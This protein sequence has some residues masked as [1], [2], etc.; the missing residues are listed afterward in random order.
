MILSLILAAALKLLTPA[1]ENFLYHHAV[2]ARAGDGPLTLLQRYDLG[3]HSCDL[4]A[5]YTLNEL[6]PNAILYSGR[7]Y[8]LP[9]LIYRY[10]GVNI[11]STINDTDYNK[12]LRIQQYNDWLK[13]NNLR[14]THYRDSRILWVPYHE[15]HCSP[16][17]KPTATPIANHL[18][19]KLT[20]PILGSKEADVSRK[21]TKLQGHVYYLI[22]G[23]GGP[24]PGAVGKSGRSTLC[25]DEYA[26][27]VTLRL[28]KLLIEQGA[29]AYMII[30]DK[31]DGIRDDEW[32]VCD[33]DETCH[34]AKIPLSQAKRLKQRVE[35]VNQLYNHHK[36]K[37][38]T[39][40]ACISIHVDS[41]SVNHRQD[42]FFCHYPTSQSS[43]KLATQLQATFARK[44]GVHRH[45][46]NYEG[47]VSERGNL[48]VLKNTLPKAVLVELANIQN[49]S[50][51]QRIVRP[52]NRQA[53]ANW[54]LEGL[55]QGS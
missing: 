36:K 20:L 10:N 39:E 42:V 43:K 18:G 50:D 2:P 34:G 24:D 9:V 23:H 14:K 35:H 49:K 51:H 28:Y 13:S 16:A 53:L 3:D 8:K 22:A 15:L 31:N 21:S 1:N 29:Q 7:K 30:Q 27:D 40:Q 47:C 41:R 12:A 17:S 33:R 44:Y 32:L 45:G 55:L 25:E 52:S 37:G 38:I 5:F 6:N 54:M 48:Y 4:E 46:G 26:Y 19:K 11:R